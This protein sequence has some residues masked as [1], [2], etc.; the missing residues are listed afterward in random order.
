MTSWTRIA[1]ASGSRTLRTTSRSDSR[2]MRVS[3]IV[4]AFGKDA[5]LEDCLR[6]LDAA[7]EAV[8]GETEVIVVLNRISDTA[9]RELESSAQPRVLVDTGDNLGFAGGVAAGLARARG[10]WV[11][12]INDDCV[13][14]PEALAELL[15][16]GSAGEDIGSVA[17]QILFAGA[18]GTINSAG[19]E[20]DE[21]GVAHERLLGQPA[22]GS[23]NEV[24]EV[25][26]ASGA[27]A[28]YRRAMLEGVGGFDQSF[29]AY[30]EDADLAWR[31]RMHGWRC[32]YAPRAVARHHH[33]ETLGH[34]SSPKYYLVGRNRVRML[35]KNATGAQL[36]RHGLSMIVY[37]LL[38]LTY[39]AATARTLA[40]LRG[41][42]RGL[43]E[44]GSYRSCGVPHRRAVRLR[45]PPGLRAALERDRA[46]GQ[47]RPTTP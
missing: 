31:A 6:S 46:Y 7:L 28:L 41:R 3:A 34:R 18:G 4:V 21:L 11:A 36:R 22:A 40:P 45:P 43:R 44:W 2:L 14:E 13:V 30:L 15:R 29:F 27:A 20:V 33:S 8:E 42:L 17:A 39:V 24:V 1:S 23:E 35:A 12:I 32:V 25:F 9:R 37:D 38:Y 47:T 26:G 19:I 16:A 5:L 10:E